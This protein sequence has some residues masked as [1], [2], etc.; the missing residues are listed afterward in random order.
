MGADQSSSL[1][2]EEFKVSNKISA[3]SLKDSSSLSCEK[4][5]P[6]GSMS[7]STLSRRHVERVRRTFSGLSHDPSLYRIALRTYDKAY[8]TTCVRCVVQGH[9]ELG[10]PCTC[11]VEKPKHQVWLYKWMEGLFLESFFKSGWFDR[12]PVNWTSDRSSEDPLTPHSPEDTICV[13]I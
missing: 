10:H 7:Q 8:P 1:S 2:L 4:R 12:P 5:W 6:M 3:S 11:Y 13:E 9:A